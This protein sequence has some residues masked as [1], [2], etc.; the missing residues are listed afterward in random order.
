MIGFLDYPVFGSLLF[1]LAEWE[2]AEQA[3]VATPDLERAEVAVRLL[4]YA[5]RFGYN[6]QLPSLS[7]PPALDLA[8][9]V[10]PGAEARVRAEVADRRPTQLRDDVAALVAVLAS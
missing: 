7:W 4:V 9:R 5:D 2:L 6:R 10:L 8:E 1:A 3:Q